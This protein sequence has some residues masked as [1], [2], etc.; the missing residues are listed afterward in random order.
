MPL[1]AILG[2]PDSFKHE[3]LFSLSRDV[4]LRASRDFQGLKIILKDRT[5]VSST[6]ISVAFFLHFLISYNNLSSKFSVG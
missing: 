4:C 2:W 3:K 1:T 5:E 6:S